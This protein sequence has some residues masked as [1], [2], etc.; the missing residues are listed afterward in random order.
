MIGEALNPADEQLASYVRA[1]PSRELRGF[2]CACA[3]LALNRASAELPAAKRALTLARR[4]IGD[5]RGEV[6]RAAL[7]AARAAMVRE[8]RRLDELAEDIRYHYTDGFRTYEYLKTYSAARAMA[9]V[10]GAL[11]ES[12]RR[13]ALEAA[14]EARLATGDFETLLRMAVESLRPL[15]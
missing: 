8:R 1:A 7:I 2:A 4:L 9:S 5:P 6:D 12:P 3:E 15:G 14:H 13:A 11:E 10:L